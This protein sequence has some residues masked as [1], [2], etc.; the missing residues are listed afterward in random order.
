MIHMPAFIPKNTDDKLRSLMQWGRLRQHHISE[1][2]FITKD[3]V[4]SFLKRQIEHGNWRAVMEVLKGKPM[5]QAGRFMLHELRDKVVR[6]LIIRMGLRKVIAV[7]L[8]I[9]LMPL[10]LAK[11]AGEVI[12]WMRNRQR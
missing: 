12:G 9:V 3:T 1:A 8:A 7:A 2:F 11:V 5:T 4:L 6:S 10:I